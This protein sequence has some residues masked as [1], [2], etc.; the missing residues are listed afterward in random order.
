[1]KLQDILKN[2]VTIDFT[3]LHNDKEL[4]TQVQIQLNALGL[5]HSKADGAYGP[6]TQRALTQFAK[7]FNLGSKVTPEFAKKLIETKSVPSVLPAPG[8]EL[9]KQ[10]E[11][12][13]LEAY[14]DPL[15]GAEPITIGWGCTR[16]PDGSEWRMGDRITEEEAVDLLLFQLEY[17]YLAYLQ[18][19]PGWWELNEN[20]QGAL[21]SFAYNLGAN[22]FGSPNFQ[23]ITRVLQN[24]QWDKIE[25]TFLLYCN[26]GSPVEDGLKRRRL[27]EAQLFNK[28][29]H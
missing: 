17:H 18:A 27:A 10:F 26:P 8:V 20:Q 28:S 6:I 19:I 24:K 14:P 22:F 11:G 3:E 7:F 16:K 5:L 23:T 2:N 1:M 15:T 25:K 12:C 13:Y 4:A 9:I 21:L 29:G